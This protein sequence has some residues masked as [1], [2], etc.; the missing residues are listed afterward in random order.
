MMLLKF[1]IGIRM[2]GNKRYVNEYIEGCWQHVTALTSSIERYDSPPPW[3]EEKFASY[4]ESQ[5]S[6]LKERL[7]KIQYDIDAV[8]TVSLI[9]RGDRIEGVRTSSGV[10]SL[11][12][13]T[14]ISSSSRS[15]YF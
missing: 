2:P 3:L 9:L 12:N 8:E 4:A 10:C 15:S 1:E 5:E 6:I 7:A 13:L 11:V 14:P